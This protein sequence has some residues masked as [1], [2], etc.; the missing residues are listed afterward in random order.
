MRAD[1]R[2]KLSNTSHFSNDLGL[3]SL[4]TVEVVMA[5]EE[6]CLTGRGRCVGGY[7]SDG[8]V[9]RNSAL[10]YRTRRPMRF[11]A[12]GSPVESV[13]MLGSNFGAVDKAVSYILSQPDGKLLRGLVDDVVC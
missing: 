10:R 7:G 13:D 8:L 12:V 3:D 9:H 4:D 6:V 11:I 2:C 5:I 1:K